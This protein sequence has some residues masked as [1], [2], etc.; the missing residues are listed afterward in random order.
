MWKGHAAPAEVEARLFNQ[1]QQ[2][3]LKRLPPGC[4]GKRDIHR[5]HSD[6]VKAPIVN[7][8]SERVGDGMS[9]HAV[10]ASGW[11][12][13]IKTKSLAELADGE[14][15]WRRRAAGL[16]CRKREEATELRSQDTAHLAIFTHTKCDHRLLAFRE[17]IEHL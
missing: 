1:L 13:L 11:P 8:R 7:Q 12:D 10:D 6:R 3:C 17:Q 9:D 14:L 5:V 2:T 4:D 15:P 16:G